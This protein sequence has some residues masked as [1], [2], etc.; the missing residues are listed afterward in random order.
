MLKTRDKESRDRWSLGIFSVFLLLFSE[1]TEPEEIPPRR[2][3]GIRLFS[4]L[5]SLRLR[6]LFLNTQDCSTNTAGPDLIGPI[7]KLSVGE[8]LVVVKVDVSIIQE[9][10]NIF[11]ISLYLSPKR[12]ILS[13]EMSE[14][15]EISSSFFKVDSAVIEVSSETKLILEWLVKLSSVGWDLLDWPPMATVSLTHNSLL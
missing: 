5:V 7:H 10:I 12:F 4:S 13:E 1:V 14:E 9:N 2:C 6:F 11:K 3:G 15:M 8:R